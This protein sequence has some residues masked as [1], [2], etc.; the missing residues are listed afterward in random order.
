MVI[1]QR[2]NGEHWLGTAVRLVSVEIFTRGYLKNAITS[3]NSPQGLKPNV[4][5]FSTGHH[6]KEGANWTIWFMLRSSGSFN[7][8]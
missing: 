6:N 7:A 4:T 3:E 8:I 1:L 2:R 5:Y